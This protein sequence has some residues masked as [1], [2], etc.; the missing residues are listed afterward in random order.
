MQ[1]LDHFHWDHR[2]YVMGVVNVTPD[3]FSGDG[4]LS[5]TETVERAT[6]QAAQFLSA[7]VDILDVGGESTRPGSRSV[8]ADEE[9]ARV[10]PV[11]KAVAALPRAVISIDSFK[12][13]VADAAL[14]A[15][16]HII[17]DVWGLRGDPAMAKTAAARGAPVVLMHNRSKPNDVELDV[18]LGGSY[19]GA[20]YDDLM[21][22]ICTEIMELVD[23]ARSAGVP[24]NQIIVDPGIGFGKTVQ[25]N[26][27]IINQLNLI[28]DLGFPVL[29]GASRKSFIGRVLDVPVE[30]RVEGTA[31]A[32]AIGISRGAN[33]IRVQSV[34]EMKRIAQ[35]TDAI[36]HAPNDG[37]L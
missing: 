31:A 25:Q 15:G 27:A 13:E 18:R 3:S 9:I 12:A 33:I 32:C 2:T 5:T 37:G 24:D 29:L 28:R 4:L 36:L 16:A 14:D 21:V 6:H 10:I 11:M 23:L 1:L 26:L 19:L 17:N 35:M 30:K 34:E 20:I 7:G 8:S 22:D